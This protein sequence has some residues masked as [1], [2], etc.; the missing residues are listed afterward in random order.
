MGALAFAFAFALASGTAREG[1]V[2]DRDGVTRGEH[3]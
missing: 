3:A 2:E 1:Q